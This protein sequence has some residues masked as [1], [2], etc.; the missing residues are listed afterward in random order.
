MEKKDA[1]K[2]RVNTNNVAYGFDQV[3]E[4]HHSNDPTPQ[5]DLAHPYYYNYHAIPNRH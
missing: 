1:I 3:V 2:F 4:K 5:E